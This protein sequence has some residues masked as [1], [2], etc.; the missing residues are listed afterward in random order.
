MVFMV[1]CLDYLAKAAFA[2]HFED[3]I[4]VGQVVM[5][6]MSIRALVIIVSTIIQG[7]NGSR[8]L[9][10]I[11]ANEV[12]LWIVEDLLELIGRELVNV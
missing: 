12:D 2:Y 10:C 4:S 1:V 11:S 9:F 6:Y 5:G 7:T 3:F 8:T